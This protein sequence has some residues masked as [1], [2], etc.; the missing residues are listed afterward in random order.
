MMIG[1]R[2]ID[3]LSAQNQNKKILIVDGNNIFGRYY[4]GSS[5]LSFCSGKP[6]GGIVGFLR[7]LIREIQEE[8]PEQVF[9]VFDGPGY[10]E[11]K[12]QLIPSYKN[13]R[14]E[15]QK[16]N[17]AI[18]V[19]DETEEKENKSWQYFRL[20]EYLNHLP[21]FNLLKA[22]Q[23]ADD[24]IA[25][26][27]DLDLFKSHN[28]IILSSDRDFYQLLTDKIVLLSP[29]GNVNTLKTVLIETGIHP[30]N[31]ALAKAMVGDRT[32][33][34]LGIHGVG[35]IS[36]CHRLPLLGKEDVVD[37]EQVKKLCLARKDNTFYPKFYAKVL[38]NFDLVEQNFRFFKLRD[39]I[40][41]EPFLIE[42]IKNDICSFDPQS[43]LTMITKMMIQDGIRSE[44]FNDLSWICKKL[45]KNL[46]KVG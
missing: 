25:V 29:D 18:D 13:R 46:G 6:I 4:A 30:N 35:F 42:K 37:I 15:R 7:C 34:V 27:T 16:V 26:L 44:E 33:N 22:E 2:G 17:R 41:V 9:I 12:R 43:N 23:E 10:L 14:N 31:F 24:L 36:V 11:K 1:A 45:S 28:K 38:N 5:Q 3:M 8:N 39:N 32:D 21:V 20:I 40:F 19:L